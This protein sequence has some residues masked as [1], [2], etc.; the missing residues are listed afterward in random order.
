MA[1]SHVLQARRGFGLLS[2]LLMIAVMVSVQWDARAADKPNIVILLADDLGWADVGFHGSPIQTPNID[3]LAAEGIQL[4]RFY[5]CPVCTPTR[6]GLMTGRYP[7]RFGL[8]KA[9]LPPHRNFAM[10]INETLMPEILAQAGYKHRGIFGKWHLGHIDKKYTP[11]RRGFTEFIGHYNGAIDYFTHEREGEL[12]WHRNLE[13]NRDEGYSTDLIAAGAVDFIKRHANDGSPFLC[14]V[15]FNAPHSPF[16]A[17]DADLA[18][19]KNLKTKGK[20]PKEK[21]TRRIYAA[22]VDSMDQGVGRILKAIDDAGI[23]DNTL[24]WFFSDNGG[25]KTQ[26]YNDP[27]RGKKSEGFD[28]GVRVPAAVRWPGVIKSGTKSRVMGAYID[29]LPTLMSIIGIDSTGG[30]PLDGVDLSGILKGALQVNR[31]ELDRVVYNYIGQSGIEVEYISATTAKYKLLVYGPAISEFE[32][33]AKHDRYLFRIDRDPNETQN[34]I[35]EEPGV[36]AELFKKAKA[37]REL[38][39][40]NGVIPYKDRDEHPFEAPKDWVAPG[41]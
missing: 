15:P 39:P 21:N 13:T 36:F 14:Y 16:Q 8:Q 9:V 3:R 22:M 20:G 30:K 4:E 34:V 26:G 19:Y 7:I 28:G 5:V 2:L 38:Q 27:L 18:K 40:A 10:D 23:S 6:A 29:V 31:L 32:L 41:K 37:F 24:V 25:T 17:K 35:D 33:G 1:F 12:D 11:T